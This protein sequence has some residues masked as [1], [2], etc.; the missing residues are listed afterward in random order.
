MIVLHAPKRLYGV[1]KIISLPKGN[2]LYIT[3]K[4]QVFKTN[5]LSSTILT[6]T[7]NLS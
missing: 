4:M 5:K 7:Q 6:G 3:K 1:S 2:E